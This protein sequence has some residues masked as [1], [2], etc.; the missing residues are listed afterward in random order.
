MIVDKTIEIATMLGLAGI[1]VIGVI[2]Q[3]SVPVRFKYYSNAA[4]LFCIVLAGVL[5]LKQRKGFLIWIVQ[6]LQRIRIKFSFLEEKRDKIKETDDYVSGF[7]RK[8]KKG[9]VIL[10]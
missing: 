3:I 10:F 5:F 9:I 2:F 4:V 6:S 8:D 7:S 1:G